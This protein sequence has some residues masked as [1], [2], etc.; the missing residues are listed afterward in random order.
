MLQ[1][2]DV[3]TAFCTATKW[4]KQYNSPV[5]ELSP[6]FP[7]KY[8]ARLQSSFKKIDCLEITDYKPLNLFPNIKFWWKNTGDVFIVVAMVLVVVLTL[9]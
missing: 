4:P 3:F 5:Q 1:F 6:Y 2:S 8:I 9:Y 7:S